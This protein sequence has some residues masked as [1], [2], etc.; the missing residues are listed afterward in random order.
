MTG[1]GKNIYAGG[2]HSA[3]GG[4]LGRAL[5]PLLLVAM[6]VIGLAPPVV[7]VLALL[8]VLSTAWLIWAMI[9]AG[10]ALLFWIGVY[11]FMR[12]PVWYAL[13][14]PLGF[15]VVLY[16]AATAIGRGSRV[17]WKGREYVAR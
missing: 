6:P 13:A 9:T 5:Y 14:Y 2:R 15:A 8:G 1:W 17:S 11:A 3:L 10:V 7:L 16:I 12:V 4:G